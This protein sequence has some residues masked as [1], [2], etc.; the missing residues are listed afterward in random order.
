[1]SLRKPVF[2]FVITLEILLI[3]LLS[4]PAVCGCFP[5]LMVVQS[6]SMEPLLRRGD[7]VF[8]KKKYKDLDSYKGRIAAYYDPFS[9][10]IVL[11]RVVAVNG[12][13]LV[14]KG[15]NNFFNDFFNPDI[16]DIV[17]VY[18]FGIRHGKG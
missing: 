15:D 14:T 9:N 8:L 13:F 16:S 17:G 5:C 12:R 18:W 11:H 3:V 10:R 1:M 4:V 6:D 2:N 7:L